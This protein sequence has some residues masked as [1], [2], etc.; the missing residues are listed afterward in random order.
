[1]STEGYEYHQPALPTLAPAPPTPPVPPTAPGARRWPRLVAMVAAMML[2]AGIGGYRVALASTGGST[3]NSVSASASA[4]TA[5]LTLDQIAAKVDPAI[6]DINTQLGNGAAAGTGMIISSTGE[7]LTNNHVVAG[8]TSINVTLTSSGQS[9][10]ATLVG[11]DA[12]HDVAVIQVSGVSGWPT[13]DAVN[14]SSA[15]V[16]DTVVAIGNALGKGGQPSVV[17]GNIAAVNQ[18]ITAGDEGGATSETLNNLI[19][20]N[21][22]IQPGDSGGATVN[23]AGQVIGMT[24]AGSTGTETAAASSSTTGFA[25]PIN[26]ALAVAKTIESGSA[27][28]TVHIGPHGQLGVAIQDANGGGVTVES[29]QDGS[30]AAS[31]GIQAGDVIT[32]VNGHSI[33]SVNDLNEAMTATH[34]GDHVTIAWTD[35]NGTS[36]TATATL[37]AGVG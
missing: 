28:G 10:P 34:V 37:T 30:A 2:L 13:I 26:D 31:A 25:V 8:A 20:I 27:S 18:T 3:A 21:A 23:A 6:V 4:S 11:Y 32:A 36:H 5:T 24:T 29:V 14:S 9:Y 7:I 22:D 35:A 15:H 12:S 17:Q 33:S 19:A 16:G 1:M